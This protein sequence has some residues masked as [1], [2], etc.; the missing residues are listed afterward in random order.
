[1]WAPG[2]TA[3]DQGIDQRLGEGGGTLNEHTMPRLDCSHRFIG[4][5][6]CCHHSSLCFSQRARIE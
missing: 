6:I 5:D 3:P 1:M 2:L 4:G